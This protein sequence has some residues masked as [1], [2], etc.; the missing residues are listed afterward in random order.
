MKK[1]SYSGQ[2]PGLG[3]RLVQLRRANRGRFLN[4]K[5]PT[6]RDSGT[7]ALATIG[8]VSGIAATAVKGSAGNG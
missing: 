6:P 1:L 5:A 4:R 3:Q 8:K 2:V 7:G